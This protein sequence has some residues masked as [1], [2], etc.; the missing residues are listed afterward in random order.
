MT[1][2]KLFHLYLVVE[3]GLC[4]LTA[5]AYIHDLKLF[6]ECTGKICSELSL[7]TLTQYLKILRHK[8]YADSSITRA[9]ISLRVYQKYLFLTGRKKT[10][11]DLFLE[12]PKCQQMIPEVLSEEEVNLLLEGGDDSAFEVIALVIYA[13]GLRVS[14]VVNLNCF[15]MGKDSLFVKGKGGKERI[16][17]IGMVTRQKVLD[18]LHL[19]RRDQDKKA[20]LFVNSKG[21]RISRQE[22]WSYIKAKGKEKGIQKNISPHTLRHSYATHMLERGADLRVIQELLGHS[23][24]TTTERYTHISKKSLKKSFIKFHPLQEE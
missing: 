1:D 6:E 9:V 21:K 18:Y 4:K 15:D 22:V 7:A 17:P 12:T 24:V 3:K 5:E 19:E 16:V 14:E 20:P 2:F 10:G 8:G 11:T 13:C 23:S